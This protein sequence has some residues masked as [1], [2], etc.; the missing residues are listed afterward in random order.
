MTAENYDE[1]LRVFKSMDTENTGYITARNLKAALKRVGLS[2]AGNE[3]KSIIKRVDYLKHG[4]INYT[5][6][7][8]ATVNLKEKLTDQM[9][10][11]TFNHFDES[12]K[13][14]ISINDMG[15]A[16][17]KIG[18][19]ASDTEINHMIEEYDFAKPGKIDFDEFK[20]MMLA[21]PTP[22]KTPYPRA[23]DTVSNPAQHM[24]NANY[25]NFGAMADLYQR[26]ETNQVNAN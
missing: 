13:G 5:T 9:I 17:K 19:A 4:K 10:Y 18:I 15:V 2:T 20:A 3:M 12:K 26:K 1:L 23:L 24:A 14:F 6:F 22:T 21:D 11:D 16:L 8:M 25:D 7:L